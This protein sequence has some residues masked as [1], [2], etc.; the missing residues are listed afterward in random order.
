MARLLFFCGSSVKR[1]VT[2]VVEPSPLHVCRVFKLLAANQSGAL[3]SARYLTP[4]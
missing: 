1:V 3:L 4:W 2:D